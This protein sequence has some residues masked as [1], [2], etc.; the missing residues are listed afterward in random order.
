MMEP[1]A[2]RCPSCGAMSW[3]GADWCGQCL[4]PLGASLFTAPEGLEEDQGRQFY[5]AEPAPAWEGAV[6]AAAPPMPGATAASSTQSLRRPTWPCAVCETEN[7]IELDSCAACGAPFSRLFQQPESG[8]H[9]DPRSAVVRSLLFP[10]LGQI[11][12]GRTAD[13]VTP[14]GLYP[15]AA[16]APPGVPLA[17]RRSGPP[18][19]PG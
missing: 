18:P 9:V 3:W 11:H 4:R 12:C 17:P 14:A 7:P 2:V 1:D 10:G 5:M 13:G 19:H 8:P 16:G 15:W 6:A